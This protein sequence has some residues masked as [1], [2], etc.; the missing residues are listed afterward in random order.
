MARPSIHMNVAA[1]ADGK[2]D[3]M[4]R[5]G[6]SIS[7]PRDK[8]RVDR[9]RADSDAVLVGGRTLHDEDPKLTVSSGTLR[10]ERKARGLPENPAKVAVASSLHLRPDCQFLTAGPARI[11]LFTTERTPADQLEQL[12]RAGAEVFVQSSGRVDLLQVLETLGAQGIRH[13]MVE[14]GGT[15]NFELL[16]LGLVDD[17]SIFIAPLIFGGAAAPTL[18][19]GNGLAAASAIPMKLIKVNHWNDGGV[20]LHYKPAPAS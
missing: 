6:A 17:L 16:R 3:S 14:G 8:E 11:L 15:L 19:D 5:R 18:A 9:L 4:E 13:L 2:I 20:L 10:L 12:R 1:T 7:T